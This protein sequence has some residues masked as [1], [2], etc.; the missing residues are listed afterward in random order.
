MEKEK[1]LLN[2][3][4][5][6]ELEEEE[7]SDD[8]QE[9]TSEDELESTLDESEEQVKTTD[10]ETKEKRNLKK[11]ATYAEK[12][13]EKER[14]EREAREAEIKKSAKLEAK[15]ELSKK[16]EFTG[17]KIVDEED[18]K[19]YEI[20][21]QLDEE[22]LDPISD[23]PKR[24]AEISRKEKANLLEE[25]KKKAKL[26]E[27]TKK[28]IEDFLKTHPD[29]KIETLANDEGYLEYA[30]DKIGRWTTSEIYDTYQLKQLNNSAEEKKAMTDK[31]A[32]D[33]AKKLTK[34]PSSNPSGN[35]KTKSIDDMTPE[36]FKE[37]WKN[38]YGN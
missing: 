27:E 14:L 12:R 25:E 19:I 37:Y 3:L 23:L 15:L 22:G 1:D 30:K 34:N 21:K 24:L 10:E 36:E 7:S 17:E 29:V 35:T 38:K 16:N 33:I 32:D 9:G 4:D 31:A 5:F 13:R 18:L 11:D 28:D 26:N 6:E 2:P 20:Q 8:K